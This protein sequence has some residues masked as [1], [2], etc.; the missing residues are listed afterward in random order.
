M[1]YQI[2]TV[3]T[4]GYANCRP[5]RKSLCRVDRFL[6]INSLLS[7]LDYASPHAATTYHKINYNRGYLLAPA[8]PRTVLAQ[9]THTAPHEYTSRQSFPAMC[10]SFVA[11]I[12]YY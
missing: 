11:N 3:N 6:Q 9:F 8:P 5:Y 1:D 10:C 4:I 2:T 12:F 7:A